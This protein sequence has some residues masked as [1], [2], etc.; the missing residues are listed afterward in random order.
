MLHRRKR[1]LKWFFVTGPRM[2]EAQEGEEEGAASL[3]TWWTRAP[4]LWSS[5]SFFSAFS[6]ASVFSS[7]D[8]S[9]SA[10]VILLVSFTRFL[11]C[12]MLTDLPFG[13]RTYIGYMCSF[14]GILVARYM[15]TVIEAPHPALHDPR[16]QNPCHQETAVQFLQCPRIF[17]P[18]LHAQKLLCR[19][20]SRKARSVSCFLRAVLCVVLNHV[21]VC[22][23]GGGRGG[24]MC[25]WMCLKIELVWHH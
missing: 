11:A 10:V 19:P 4:S 20:S 21:Y 15:E 16:W 1:L 12:S 14:A 3:A 17:C 5:S 25:V 23:G 8:T 2:G 22:V 24:G 18:S 9:H 13:V 6:L 7:L